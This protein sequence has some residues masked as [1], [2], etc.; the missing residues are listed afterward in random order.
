MI[1]RTDADIRKVNIP[2]VPAEPLCKV[3]DPVEDGL[4]DDGAADSLLQEYK[5]SYTSA[6]PFVIIPSSV[7]GRALR[8][9]QPFLF[10]AILT[11]TT[12]RQAGL[13]LVLAAKLKEQISLRVI[14][15]SQQTLELLQGI[16]VYT[17]WYDFSLATLIHWADTQMF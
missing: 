16:L 13:Q 14:H 11:V 17:A 7:N 15:H 12:Y 8:Q 3:Y 6:F 5:D 1:A 2:Y 4:L 10:L 9:S